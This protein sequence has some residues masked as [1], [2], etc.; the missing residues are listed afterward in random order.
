MNI[1]KQWARI[2]VQATIYR[3]FRIGRDGYLDQSE[4]IAKIYVYHNL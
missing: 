3:R 1:I 2:L 4:A